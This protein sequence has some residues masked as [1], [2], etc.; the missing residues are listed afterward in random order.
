MVS[1]HPNAF[2]IPAS[3]ALGVA[4]NLIVALNTMIRD[5]PEPELRK[6]R[7]ALEVSTDTADDIL[8]NMMILSTFEMLSFNDGAYIVAPGVRYLPA[9]F[10]A[11]IVHGEAVPA[12]V[13][14]SSRIVGRTPAANVNVSGST[15]VGS[16]LPTSFSSFISSLGDCSSSS[17]AHLWANR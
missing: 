17:I 4:E 16:K 14:S 1:N 15:F 8:Y 5:L 2:I 11:S 9:F 10:I 13:V 3:T 6:V 12:T 7:A